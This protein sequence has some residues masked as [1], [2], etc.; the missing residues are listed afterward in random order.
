VSYT[1]ENLTAAL[2]AV[3]AGFRVFP[4]TIYWDGKQ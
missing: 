1:K 2:E 4:A 3:R